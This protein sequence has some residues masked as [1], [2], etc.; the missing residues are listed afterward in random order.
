MYSSFY[1]LTGIPFQLTPDPRFYFGSRTHSK[2][3]AYLTYGLSQGEGFIVITGEVGAGKTTVVGNLL[4]NIDRDRYFISKVVTTQ[5]EP[6]TILRM[7]AGGLGIQHEGLD[8]A[9][10]LGR[11]EAFM[12]E[13]HQAGKRVLVIVDEAQNL[14]N[15]TLEELRMLSN[16]QVGGSALVQLVLV[17]QP[18]FRRRLAKDPALEQ[19]RQR[20][21]AAYHLLPMADWDETREY[22]HHRLRLVG[23][24]QDPSF[25]DDA[26]QAI[27][28][29]CGGMPRRLNQLCSRLLLF[30]YLEEL[31]QIDEAIVKQV[32]SE[33]IVERNNDAQ[34][35]DEPSPAV[36]PVGFAAT[37]QDAPASAQASA[38]AQ[39]PAPRALASTAAS[40]AQWE[41]AGVQVLMYGF[42]RQVRDLDPGVLNMVAAALSGEDTASVS[43]PLG[44][45]G[46]GLERYCAQMMMYGFLKEVRYRDPA[47]VAQV[48]NQV[49]RESPTSSAAPQPAP[50]GLGAR[51]E[52]LEERA[53]HQDRLLEKTVKAL[54]EL[55]AAADKAD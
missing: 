21:I 12:Q 34:G 47:E 19:V 23:W 9:A 50:S 49:L 33:F 37:E 8:K 1:K 5:L 13:A 54:D 29:F 20:V 41:G 11:M 26:I 25:T 4:N 7:V 43:L 6:D 17:G 14:S 46:G 40:A 55:L 52:A 3:M 10:V 18:E 48:L 51:L 44:E 38:S 32:I 42:L 45:S 30:G 39:A 53:R 35:Q 24:D 31:H 22:I 36:A 15:A 27:H 16:Y 28:D 2:A